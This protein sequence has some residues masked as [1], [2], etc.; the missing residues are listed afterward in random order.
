MAIKFKVKGDKVTITCAKG[1]L[2]RCLRELAKMEK[3]FDK[4]D[5]LLAKEDSERGQ[6]GLLPSLHQP[7]RRK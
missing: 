3:E 6:A 7:K 5:K 2:S 1:Q 4:L